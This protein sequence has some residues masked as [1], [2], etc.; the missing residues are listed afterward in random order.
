M[1]FVELTDKQF[2]EFTTKNMYHFSQTNARYDLRNDKTNST[3]YRIGLIDDNQEVVAATI[4]TST[5]I[6]KKFNY[7]YA[8]RGPILDFTNFKV[9]DIFFYELDKFL[10]QHN[11]LHIR[12]DPYIIHNIR[13]HKGNILESYADR[14][15]SIIEHLDKLGYEH[16]GFHI[17]YDGKRQ[18]RFDSVLDVKG[19]TKEE[20]FNNMDKLR[21]RNI[22]KT[23]KNGIKIKYLSREELPIFREF[24]KDTVEMK[25]FEDRGD[26][27]YYDSYDYYGDRVKVPMAY[28]DIDEYV[29]KE[30][31]EENKLDKNI[32]KA[33]KDLQTKENLTDKQKEKLENKI[34]NLRTQL[35][36]HLEKI[37]ELTAAQEKYGNELPVSAGFFYETDYEVVYFAGGTSNEFRHYAGS[38]AIQWEMIKY[39]IDQGLDQYNFYG[40]TGDFSED[41]EDAGVIKFKEGFNAYVKEYVG[42]FVKPVNKLAY[43]AFLQLKKVKTYKV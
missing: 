21:Q 6:L 22:K 18:H 28:I 39:T 19:K 24:M 42:D 26:D 17:G 8:T 13:D 34:E 31:K 3:M 1:K 32:A 20:V 23:E 7:F 38:Y 9:V 4:L 11:A 12:M 35:K 10:K 33:E 27:Y 14:T 2:E 43:K 15:Q 30:R 36:S 5:P 29:A 37:E 41:A 40:I 25:S 16:Q